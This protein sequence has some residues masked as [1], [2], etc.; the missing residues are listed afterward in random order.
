MPNES[1]QT[2]V[3]YAVITAAVVLVLI[4]IIGLARPNVIGGWVDK[5]KRSFLV[6]G[7]L[8]NSKSIRLELQER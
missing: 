6:S 3:E 7:R 5:T 1:G 4:A 8:D 2:T